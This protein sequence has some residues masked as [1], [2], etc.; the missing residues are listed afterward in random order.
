MAI[1]RA[2]RDLSVG[3]K[4][5]YHGDIFSSDRLQPEALKALEEQQK[6]APANLP[7]VVA[8]PRLKAKRAALAKIN[9]ITA[10]DFLETDDSALAKA[11]KSTE[12]EVKLYKAELTAQFSIPRPKN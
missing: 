12:Q 2:L 8:I 9:V 4:T 10:G 3:K 1:Y 6:I 11:L 7:P 5:I